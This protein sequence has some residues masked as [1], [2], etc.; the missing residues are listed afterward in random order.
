MKRCNA[1]LPFL[2]ITTFWGDGPFEFLNTEHLF[3]NEQNL[4]VAAHHYSLKAEFEHAQGS[5]VPW[6]RRPGI[7][8]LKGGFKPTHGLLGEDKVLQGTPP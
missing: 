2:D 5:R 4:V 3:L 8:K 7:H 1:E 6:A